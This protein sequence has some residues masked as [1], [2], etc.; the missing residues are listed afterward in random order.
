MPGFWGQAWYM[1]P[2]EVQVLDASGMVEI[3]SHTMNHANIASA[4]PATR[5]YQLDVSKAMLEKLLGHPVL[6]F[7]YP[8]GKF[9]VAATAAVE[10]AG[11]QTGTTEVPGAILSWTTR[12]IWP[13][14]RVGGGENLATFVQNLGRPEPT[15]DIVVE[16]SPPP[17]TPNGMS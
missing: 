5:A 14:V 6:D 17:P 10:A 11:Y 7:C 9:N 4:S 15:V 12:L 13:R 2:Q 3:A 1:T 16:P 8:S